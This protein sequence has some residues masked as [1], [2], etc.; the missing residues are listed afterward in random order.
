[1]N[2]S[3]C[4]HKKAEIAEKLIEVSFWRRLSIFYKFVIVKLCK[5]NINERI[6]R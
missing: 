5:F 2:V 4:P 1:M 3:I 6:E